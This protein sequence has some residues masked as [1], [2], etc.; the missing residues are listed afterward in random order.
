MTTFPKLS[1]ARYTAEEGGH[2]IENLHETF[3]PIVRVRLGSEWRVLLED[4]S[5]IQAVLRIE[6]KTPYRSPL[7][8]ATV[9]EKRNKVKKGLGNRYCQ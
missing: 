8:L 9:Y 6:D 5:D 3:G 4:L 1:A 7:L 2:M